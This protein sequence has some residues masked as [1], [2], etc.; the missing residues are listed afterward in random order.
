[1]TCPKCS[2]R[3]QFVHDL[4]GDI[5]CLSCGATPTGILQPVPPRAQVCS[6][7]HDLPDG[8]PCYPCI[9]A[10]GRSSPVAN[11]EQR[12]GMRRAVRK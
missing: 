1:M 4:S 3:N 5:V 6:R 11:A 10:V 9:D 12:S 2:A 7:G 8:P